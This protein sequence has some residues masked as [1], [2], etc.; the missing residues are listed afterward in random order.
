M[1]WSKGEGKV[2]IPI[3]FHRGLFQGDALSPLLFCLCTAPLSL[4]LRETRGVRSEF[5]RAALTHLMFMDDLK[6][7]SESA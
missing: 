1:A 4:V 6:V 3:N 5:Q 2:S 7:Y